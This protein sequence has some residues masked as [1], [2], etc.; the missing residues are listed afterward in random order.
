MYVILHSET[1]HNVGF[2]SNKNKLKIMGKKKF[3]FKRNENG[4]NIKVCCASCKFREFNQEGDRICG[5]IQKDVKASH[6][7]KKWEHH[8]QL[9]NAGL[10]IG[11]VKSW[12]YLSYYRGLWIEQRE[13]LEARRID[14]TMVKSAEEFRKEYEKEYGS[15]VVEI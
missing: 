10:G 6:H 8:E 4:I 1:R 7:F 2:K 5:R 13:A 3:K 11:K 15:V 14:G 9:R 12:K